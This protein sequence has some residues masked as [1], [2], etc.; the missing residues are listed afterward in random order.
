MKLMDVVHRQP[1]P[2][3]WNEEARIPWQAPHISKRLLEEHLSQ[4]HDAASRRSETIDKHVNWIHHHVLAGKPAK[5]LDLCCGPGLYTS[6]LSRLGHECVGIDFSPAAIAYARDCAEAEK[7][8][9]L[10][11]QEDIRAADYGS[12][13]GLI[14]LTYGEFNV[15]S[16]G[17]A[18]QILEKSYQALK[19]NGLVLLE[20]RT[21]DSI[22]K[23]G[24]QSPTWH[25]EDNGL[26]YHKPHLCLR[27]AFWYEELSTLTE[28][29]FIIDATTG[30]LKHYEESLQAYT[31]KHYRSLLLECGFGKI[32]F[33]S[34]LSGELEEFHDWLIVIL[35]PKR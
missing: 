28:R 33:P 26:I 27:E 4:K 15:F 21:F 8:P 5:I 25:S 7:L 1:V 12:G 24:K 18:K 30:A 19:R 32:E 31:R 6:R 20:A 29:Y 2:K 16:R 34:S 14:M 23:G 35:S 9:C 17:D 3:P 11:V 13:Y 22:R 10:Y